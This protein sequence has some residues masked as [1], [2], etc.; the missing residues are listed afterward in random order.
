M[1]IIWCGYVRVSTT[2]QVDKESLTAQ[3]YIIENY[4]ASNKLRLNNVFSEVLS[5]DTDPFQRKAI[6]DVLS[7]GCR[8]I[9]IKHID[10]LGRNEISLRIFLEYL[11]KNDYKLLVT[12]QCKIY[13]KKTVSVET[14]GLSLLI[15]FASYERKNT[16]ERVQNSMSHLKKES[17]YLGNVPYDKKIVNI[18]G[19]KYLED[20]YEKIKQL[21]VM[22]TL[23][24]MGIGYPTL[25]KIIEDSKYIDGTW[26]K[27]RIHS[28]FL[29]HGKGLQV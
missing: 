19:V 14:L 15:V 28:L 12:D 29:S 20:D 5:G 18:G 23:Y 1:D 17:R 8:G 25:G 9:V 22:R 7:T 26:S 16:A 13:D 21:N 4:C 11:F 3:K 2:K 24:S 27:G 10:R 6:R